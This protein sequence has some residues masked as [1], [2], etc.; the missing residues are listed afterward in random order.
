MF[1]IL[2]DVD[3]KERAIQL[4][5]YSVGKMNNIFDVNSGQQSS[6]EY[7][8]YF[9]HLLRAE[10]QFILTIN[11][12]QL[13][14]RNL[15]TLNDLN[16][17]WKTVE[18]N[19]EQSN[20]KFQTPIDEFFYSKIGIWN[21]CNLCGIS[22]Y[23]RTSSCLT[24]ECFHRYL[25]NRHYLSHVSTA[26]LLDVF[27][28]GKTSNEDAQVQNSMV[29]DLCGHDRGTEELKILELAREVIVIHDR[30]DCD[31]GLINTEL[32]SPV[33][34]VSFGNKNLTFW[35]IEE[36]IDLRS[37]FDNWEDV[38]SM[39]RWW[40]SVIFHEGPNY[41]SGHY[42][43]TSLREMG[44]STAS[45][46][47]NDS[48]VTH[49][50]NVSFI[51]EKV[52]NTQYGY[53]TAV[54]SLYSNE[55]RN[56]TPSLF[57]TKKRQKEKYCREQRKDRYRQKQR[58]AKK[59]KKVSHAER[60]LPESSSLRCLLS[61]SHPSWTQQKDD[62]IKNRKQ[63]KSKEK[64]IL[65]FNTTHEDYESNEEDFHFTEF[66]RHPEN[67]VLLYYF[68]SGCYAFH[69][70]KDDLGDEKIY[71]NFLRELRKEFVSDKVK[72]NIMRNY[73]IEVNGSVNGVPPLIACGCCG[74]REFIRGSDK[75]G[76]QERGGVR[77]KM[78]KVRKLKLLEYDKDDANHL[79]NRIAQ[80]KI[81]IPIDSEESTTLILPEDAISFFHDKP[82][83]TF[84]H[85]HKEFITSDVNDAEGPDVT[86]CLDCYYSMFPA[87]SIKK[88]KDLSR[89][90]PLSIAAGYDF[91]DYNRIKLTKPNEFESCILSKVRKF[92]TVLKLQDNM[93]QR[94]DYTQQTL[95][96]HVVTFDHDA[97]VVTSTAL[98]GFHSIKTSFQ[99]QLICEDEKRD[100]LIEKAMGSSIIFGRPYVIRQWL[101]VLKRINILYQ[102]DDIP[103]LAAI[104]KYTKEAN[105]YV[106]ENI[107]MT[108]DDKDITDELKEGDDI[109]KVRSERYFN[110]VQEKSIENV[111]DQM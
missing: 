27:F 72:E 106:L 14:N 98:E 89:I 68:N 48:E 110:N 13:G 32:L 57:E 47:F 50:P 40:R 1:P 88:N 52:T 21:K 23:F 17:L 46:T 86:L 56:I 87:E 25:N 97:P 4:L 37:Y 83:D 54:V 66:H 76:T 6:A 79:R 11:S 42:T 31:A 77:Y 45:F 16:E 75:V 3:N 71:K 60:S 101:L 84:Y 22:Y 91:G 94:R 103:Q 38:D 9:L 26:D 7:L 24:F 82:K 105:E 33:D 69:N 73:D 41:N 35:S 95:R 44:N 51:K 74:K 104:T 62:V 67:A 109:A 18:T 8:T 92:I 111:K 100:H 107:I 90:P 5:I 64:F 20:E 61:T 19:I 78:T 39:K 15:L 34:V 30:I 85:L 53:G 49:I 10:S 93:A 36:S 96:G 81:T 108:T 2:H 102:H 63:R 99:L 29:C 58:N 12:E 80:G 59:R 55:R 43:N 70:M 65:N 28:R